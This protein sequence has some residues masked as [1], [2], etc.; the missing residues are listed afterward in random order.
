MKYNL[1]IP[2]AGKGQRMLNAGY[3]TPKPLLMAGDKTI[4]EQS[5]DSIDIS[6]C[7]L[8]FI[9]RKDQP[10]VKD[11]IIKKWPNSKIVIAAKDTNGSLASCMLAKH[12]IDNNKPLIICTSDI[13]FYPKY[14]PI[15]SDF[16][17]GTILVFKS[18]SPDYSYA[19]IDAFQ[20][21]IRTAEKEVISNHACV[22]VYCFPTGK[23]FC[24]AATVTKPSK[25]GEYYIA[26][27][28]NELK[29]EAVALE[30]TNMYV[31]G[32]P[33]ELEFFNNVINKTLQPK[34]FV[35][36][37]DHS[38]FHLKNKFGEI[39]DSLKLEY[40][41]VGC[42]DSKD[43]D[44][45]D[46][47]HKACDLALKNDLFGLAFCRSGNG[48]NICANKYH[49]DIISAI[50][51]DYTSVMY[52]VVHNCA[53][54]FAIP[55]KHEYTNNQIQNILKIISNSKFEGGRHQRRVA[56]SLGYA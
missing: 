16:L 29:F 3:I 5:I 49:R 55:A 36:C 23:I 30:V 46:Y 26:P 53:N 11:F 37:S 56:R 48:V 44:Y 27:V 35:L 40:E 52:A 18:N 33:G 10:E 9:V 8:I 51:N 20:N 43:C 19:E 14:K 12:L 22:G 47:V 2:L 45:V 6:D 32:I 7:D 38:G 39:L 24:N 25:N 13:S 54:F 15:Q 1:L 41:D 21:V 50:A 31:M 34:R 4:L 28:Y 42:F 17:A